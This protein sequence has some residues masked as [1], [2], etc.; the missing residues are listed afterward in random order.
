MTYAS[1]GIFQIQMIDK[2][3]YYMSGGW[4]KLLGIKDFFVTLGV[5]I[6]TLREGGEG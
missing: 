4:G 5:E 6:C 3:K 2:I 1:Y